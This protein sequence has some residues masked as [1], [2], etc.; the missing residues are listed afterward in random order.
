MT[1]LVVFACGQLIPRSNAQGPSG[2]QTDQGKVRNRRT[3]VHADSLAFQLMLAKS[4]NQTLRQ[5]NDYA[6]KLHLRPNQHLS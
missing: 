3:T 4:R 1:K 2:L 5:H 6:R